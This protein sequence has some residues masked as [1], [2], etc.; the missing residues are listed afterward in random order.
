MAKALNVSPTVEK[1]MIPIYKINKAIH[2]PNNLEQIG[3]GVVVNLN[4]EYFIFGASHVFEVFNE[5]AVLI[6]AG[7]ENEI[8]EVTGDRF[9]TKRGLSGTHEDDPVD[10]S[11][12]HI[13]S[14]LSNRLKRIALTLEDLDLEEVNHDKSVYLICG[15]RANKTKKFGN[16]LYSK[17]DAFPSVEISHEEYKNYGVFTDLHIA[18]AYDKKIYINGLLQKTPTLHG[19]SGGPIIKLEGVNYNFKKQST[20]EKQKLTAIVIEYKNHANKVDRVLIGT[21]ISVHL[22]LIKRFLPDLKIK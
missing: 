14:E 20:S 7:D 17:P 16:H 19:L 6:G 9:S 12:F 2:K 22:K 1:S 4:S 13:Q 21:R 18:L 5:T 11:V 8:I 10:A 15:Y 3:T